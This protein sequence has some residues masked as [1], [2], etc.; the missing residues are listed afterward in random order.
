MVYLVSYTWGCEQCWMPMHRFQ[1]Q[2][3]L[4]RRRGDRERGY[5]CHRLTKVE[6]GSFDFG[7]INARGRERKEEK[8]S[9]VEKTR[10]IVVV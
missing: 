5:K 6:V 2:K 10:L 9:R 4:R 3:Y 1:I 8:E 7:L